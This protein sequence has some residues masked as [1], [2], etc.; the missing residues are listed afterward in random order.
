M[1]RVSLLVRGLLQEALIQGQKVW[2]LDFG[3]NPTTTELKF[4]GKPATST[5]LYHVLDLDGN[6]V[7]PKEEPK[8]SR[9]FM[10]KM[11]EAMVRHHTID[12]ILLEAQ[13]Q[14]RISFYMTSYGEEASIVGSAAGLQPQDEVFL[15][16]REGA[17]LTYRGYTIQ[18]VVAQCMGNIEC[19][20]K[21]RQMP[22][23]YGSRKLNVHVIGSTV[24]T[25]IP[26]AAGAGYAFRL[27]NE[28]ET[29]ENKKRI[30]AVFFG[31]GAAS[32]GDFYAGVNFAAVRGSQTL[33]IARNN[34]FAISTPTPTQ[35]KGDG[36]LAR[37]VGN[38]VPSARIDG[39]DIL[40]VL[41]AVRRS[42]EMILRENTP[43]LLEM[44][45]YRVSHHSTSDDSA[46]YR[47]DD[48]KERFAEIFSPLARFEKYLVR[49]S[50]WSAEQT[51]QLSQQVRKE[52]LQEL[53]RQEN[54]PKWPVDT[55]HDDVYKEKTP[56][57]QEAQ[58]EV[59]EHYERNKAAYKH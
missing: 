6:V 30:A 18:E 19:E 50:W 28:R 14:G 43:V 45:T 41:Q 37:G 32:E 34:G 44:I 5:P 2:N 3:S 15:Q 10:V 38:G 16:Y 22:I 58:R 47:L 1:F 54:I 59:M 4:H 33:F 40:A 46:A 56:E 24:A 53:R 9:E 27:E 55:M 23:H 49:K 21:G 8:V 20:L 11:M 39:H 7:N 57:M 35:Y 42:R 51:K 17:L 48:E 25:Q 52:T 29:D 36:I 31:D 12:G 26:H 13:R